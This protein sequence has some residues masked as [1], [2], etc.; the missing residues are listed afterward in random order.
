MKLLESIKSKMSKD[1]NGENLSHLD[2]TKVVL[3]L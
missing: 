1:K 3:V 2:I